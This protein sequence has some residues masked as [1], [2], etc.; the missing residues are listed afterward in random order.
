MKRG[1]AG[2]AATLLV[3]G[4]LGLAGL[5]PGAGT[6]Q[7]TCSPGA[8][9]VNGRCYGPNH[10]CPGQSLYVSQG[11]PN[12][13]VDWDMNVCHTWYWVAVGEGNVSPQ[14]WDG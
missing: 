13:D 14:V 12:R 10:W 9:V 11:G 6:A 5:G 4:G 3:S 8:A 7:A 1:I 2:L